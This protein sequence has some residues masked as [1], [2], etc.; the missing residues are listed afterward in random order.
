VSAPEDI[1]TSDA[2]FD[3]RAMEATGLSVADIIALGEAQEREEQRRVQAAGYC[4][5]AGAI[6]HPEPCCWH[7]AA[8]FDR[9][10]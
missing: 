1:H 4:C 9:D 8:V 7:P 2:A 6:A 10:R 3:R 5:V